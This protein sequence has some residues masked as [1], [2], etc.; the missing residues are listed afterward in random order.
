MSGKNQQNQN[1]Q[2]QNQQKQNK[3]NQN[4]NCLLYTS[5]AAD[6]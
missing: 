3:Q 2:N 5:D 6:E 4:Q 1:Q